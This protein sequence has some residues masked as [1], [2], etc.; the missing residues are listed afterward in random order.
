MHRGAFWPF[1]FRWIYH[2]HKGQMKRK[3]DW[4]AIHSPKKQ[5]NNLFCFFT[6]LL[7]TAPPKNCSFFPWE[8]AN[9]LTV[10]CIWPLAYEQI[11]WKGNWQN[12]P[13]CGVLVQPIEFVCFEIDS[14]WNFFIRQTFYHSFYWFVLLSRRIKLYFLHVHPGL[15]KSS[16]KINIHIL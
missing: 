10:L 4:K 15:K 3:A 16:V 13:M 12:A 14:S 8:D 11:H 6:F 1:L 9:L 2:C 7:L 5:T